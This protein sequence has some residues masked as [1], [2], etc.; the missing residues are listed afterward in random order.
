[1]EALAR[2]ILQRPI[3]IQVRRSPSRCLPAFVSGQGLALSVFGRV[4]VSVFVCVC[5]LV[6][7][8]V[9][10]WARVGRYSLLA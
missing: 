7:V 3:E 6:C 4:C 5:V 1:M 9:C 10:G 8:G 2:R